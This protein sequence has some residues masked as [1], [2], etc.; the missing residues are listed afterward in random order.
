MA[1]LTGGFFMIDTSD[2][3][4]GARRPRFRILTPANKRPQGPGRGAHSAIPLFGKPHALA[5]PIPEM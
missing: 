4:E 3:A 2:F 5:C 1:Y